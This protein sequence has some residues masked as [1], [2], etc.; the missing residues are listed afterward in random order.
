[1]PAKV[2]LEV[3]HGSM[4]GK[5]FEYDSHNLFM[6]G[7]RSH[8]QASIDDDYVSRHQFVLEANPPSARLMD[9]NSL[10]G[11]F[12]NDR[13]YGGREEGDTSTEEIQSRPTYV[14]L[15]DG[16]RIRVGKTELLVRIIAPPTCEHCGLE[17][18]AAPVGGT[19][20]AASSLVQCDAC[21]D[22]KAREL[23]QELS[24][25][26]G[27]C[28]QCGA[29]IFKTIEQNESD[30]WDSSDS[31]C[32][33]CRDSAPVGVKRLVQLARRVWKQFT[34]GNEW[35]GYE[36]ESE[37]G[38]GNMG[39]VYKARRIKDGRIVAIKTMLSKVAVSDDSR[40][41]FLREI[42]VM[43]Q[44]KHPNLVSF[45]ESKTD[46]NQFFFVM[47]FCNEGSFESLMKKMVA[48]YRMKRPYP[49][50]CNA[51][52]AFTRPTTRKSYIET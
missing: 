40:K 28:V 17:L 2:I 24:N 33:S 12:V 7:R 43:R 44:L 35:E 6:L 47:E 39:Q 32:S 22:S 25:T 3:T 52:M 16:D 11:T 13:K 36:I 51:W 1:M 14:D 42:D 38:A 21:R 49:C 20:V 41:M 30:A 8:C 50:C 9:M 10:H 46:R 23:N 19:L 45:I 27:R 29:D 15:K 48:K 18:A 37:L 5:C 26:E 31:L 34:V 4:L